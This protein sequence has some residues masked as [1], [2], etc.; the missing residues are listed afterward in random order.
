M[1][2]AAPMTSA[3][4][5]ARRSDPLYVQVV[6]RQSRVT[7]GEWVYSDIEEFSAEQLALAVSRMFQD[8]WLPAGR[9]FVR[10]RPPS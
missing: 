4:L 6:R 2:P 7:R 8:G 9:A 1:N 5:S 10:T 3:E